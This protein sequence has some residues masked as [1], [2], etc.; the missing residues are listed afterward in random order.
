M[1]VLYVSL[2]VIVNK[3]MAFPSIDYKKNFEVYDTAN[4][5]Y[6]PT[7]P[8]AG[9]WKPIT[10][11]SLVK[12][13]CND[14][15][16]FGEE[17]LDK[18]TYYVNT[19]Q[20][21]TCTNAVCYIY[22]RSGDVINTF[23]IDFYGGT[24]NEVLGYTLCTLRYELL[25]DGFSIAPLG[26][27]GTSTFSFESL[28]EQF[29]W[30]FTTYPMIFSLQE[31]LVH[32]TAQLFNGNDPTYRLSGGGYSDQITAV[33][34]KTSMP[35]IRPWSSYDSL[36]PSLQSPTA[37]FKYF[38]DL[39]VEKGYPQVNPLQPDQIYPGYEGRLAIFQSYLDGKTV[40]Y[41]IHH[42]QISTVN[43]Y[44]PTQGFD[45]NNQTSIF[46]GEMHLITPG[47]TITLSGLT[48][49]Y[50]FLNGT[51][52]NVVPFGGDFRYLLLTDTHMDVD[53][54][55]M[56]GTFFN[57]A[58]GFNMYADTSACDAETTG[59]HKGFA[60]NYGEGS[61]TV[62]VTH[63]IYDGMP[64]HQFYAAFKAYI[65][66]VFG[67]DT[68]TLLSTPVY[69][70]SFLV[71]EQF[72][73]DLDTQLNDGTQGWVSSLG[74]IE[75]YYSTSFPLGST[76]YTAGDPYDILQTISQQLPDTENVG[77]IVANLNYLE[78]AYNVYYA[79]DGDFLTGPEGSTDAICG[80]I[81]REFGEIY[82]TRNLSDPTKFGGGFMVA[83]GSAYG[84]ADT[85]LD[86]TV[87]NI[88]GSIATLFDDEEL[89]YNNWVYGIIKQSLTPGKKIGYIFMQFS[90][91]F[92]FVPDGDQIWTYPIAFNT[93]ARADVLAAAPDK[94]TCGVYA[95]RMVPMMQF[96][97]AKNVDAIIVDSRCNLG[98]FDWWLPQFLG[99][100]RYFNVDVNY[101]NTVN[102]ESPAIDYLQFRGLGDPY[103]GTTEKTCQN[104]LE[105]AQGYGP[106][107]VY[108]GSPGNDK[109]VV[110]MQGTSSYSAGNNCIFLMTGENN[111]GDIGNHTKCKIMNCSKGREVSF[112]LGYPSTWQAP[113]TYFANPEY[114]T[115]QQALGI[116]PEAAA[117]Q[118]KRNGDDTL[119]ATTIV[120]NN[121]AVSE[122]SSSTFPWTGAVGN[123]ALPMDMG[124]TVYPD[125]GF[126]ENTR[127]IL[128]GWPHAQQPDKNDYTTW[129]D[130]WLETSIQEA[131][132][133]EW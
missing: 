35:I 98:G 30:Q 133:T 80:Q 94:T 121:S 72:S 57:A 38:N 24:L 43:N 90:W 76:Y 13:A 5:D 29:G 59:A 88:A 3:R 129:R 23:D 117:G 131:L 95:C 39:A 22:V 12:S 53:A 85:S 108:H 70:D 114:G 58:N 132:S 19:L 78:E 50:A 116:I 127:P 25:S 7:S 130:S 21:S 124:S 48:N 107:T 82:Q 46:V 97:S 51:Y 105:S 16:V 96:F 26:F 61:A 125:F 15:Q 110:W 31:D 111:D 65:V 55:L 79:F 37:L 66:E 33:W 52:N 32:L 45:T 104:F 64:M 102:G 14:A 101:Y 28:L 106:G 40:T 91:P 126:C 68:H 10:R 75:G 87:W 69:A 112:A 11:A 86:R 120:T 18:R 36:R 42:I 73:E 17:I 122:L 34:E 128:S 100:E 74:A 49:S 92:S 2:A 20:D 41:P 71:Q 6:E 60:V 103:T 47:S 123:R 54:N 119:T 93:W 77:M 4:P 63:H 113:R 115:A 109:K 84:G 8:F 62:S 1:Y 99:G 67:P 9:W 56:T 44:V 83:T 89:W 118:F 81:Q 27:I